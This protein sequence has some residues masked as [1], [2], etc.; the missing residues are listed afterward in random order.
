MR[1]IIP[2]Q[3]PNPPDDHNPSAYSKLCLPYS[4]SDKNL[5]LV[6]VLGAT[7]KTG[8]SIVNGLLAS[9]NYVRLTLPELCYEG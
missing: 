4:M 6:L 1:Y 9:G 5:P 3:V 2:E 7:G 8:R